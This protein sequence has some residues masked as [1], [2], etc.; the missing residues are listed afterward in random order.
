[1]TAPMFRSLDQLSGDKSPIPAMLD[2]ADEIAGQAADVERLRDENASL[3][4]RVDELEDELEGLREAHEVTVRWLGEARRELKMLRR[5]WDTWAAG[6][7]RV[8]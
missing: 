8:L 6:K 2:A 4:C 1:M 5:Q 3:R 7:A